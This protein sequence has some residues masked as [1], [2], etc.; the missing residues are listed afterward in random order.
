MVFSWETLRKGAVMIKN[1]IKFTSLLFVFLLS[2]IL[3]YNPV[4]FCQPA[5]LQEGMDQYKQENYKEAIEAFKKARAEDPDS[6]VAAFYL[7]L[8]YKQ[9]FDYE[10]AL[11]HFRDAVTLTPRIKEALIELVD[12]AMQLGDIEEA[13]RW[14][15]VAE[16]AD[17]L[18]AK[19]AFL[20]GL[21]LREEG[22]N[23]EAEEAFEKAKSL[24]PTIA[25]ASDI[26]IALGHIME[27]ELKKAK[28][29]FESAIT[30]DPQSD[31]AGFAR[32]YLDTVE[33][34]LEL[35][36]P[37]R[38]TLGMFGQYD[39][40]M[41]LK[42]NDEAQASIATN[43]E[44][45][46]LNSSFRVNY[47]PA[48]QGPWLF[49][50]RYAVMSSLHEKNVHS[51]DSFSNYVSINP[52]YNFGN[53]A[54]NLSTEYSHSMVRG[55]SYKKYS[56]S[57]S[58]GP[59]FRFAIKGN[60]LLEIFSGYT[61]T[62]YFKPSLAPEEDRDSYG[63]KSYA[64]WMWL[65]KEESL[66]NLRYQ[67]RYLNTDGKNWDNISHGFSANFA[68]PVA[69]RVKLQLNGS[70]KDQDF[71]NTH[72][73]FDVKRDDNIYSFSGGF[74]WEYFEDTTFVAQYSY[75]RNESN[76]KAYDYTRNLFTMGVEY[77]F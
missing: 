31:L 62:E 51:H 63:Y 46:V 1:T 45:N 52:G 22:K 71:E 47:V 77:R 29:S 67:F 20:K 65:F 11:G 36:R 57:F 56:G 5:S 26:Q 4:A 6:S 13:K 25:Q 19:T 41:V 50:A 10:K 30:Q 69:E 66:L 61:N 48:M 39:D 35:E 76:I 14:I 73:T 64:S 74:T 53:F 21:I 42:S 33:R 72:T 37:F 17:V 54:V 60:Q 32:Q 2:T 40:N 7:G 23:R 38:F 28:E 27:R 15:G 70:F 44:S 34:R 12:V 68:M 59:L 16:E 3:L 18:P 49:N 55:P 24:D 8:A 43:E 9:T 58:S 75:N